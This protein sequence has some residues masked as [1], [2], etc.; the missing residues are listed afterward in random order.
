MSLQEAKERAH[1]LTLDIEEQIL[2]S[3]PEALHGLVHCGM[4][5]RKVWHTPTLHLLKHC[6]EQHANTH[7][8]VI[9]VPDMKSPMKQTK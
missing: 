7:V 6:V 9:E 5:G 1:Q 4:G 2:Q 8:T 3:Q